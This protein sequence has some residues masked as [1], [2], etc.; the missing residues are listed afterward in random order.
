MQQQVWEERGGDDETIEV[1]N[2][3]NQGTQGPGRSGRAQQ[4]NAA[5][6]PFGFATGPVERSGE[7]KENKGSQRQPQAMLEAECSVEGGF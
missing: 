2:V 1:C 6:P 7:E 5:L 3:R 4:K